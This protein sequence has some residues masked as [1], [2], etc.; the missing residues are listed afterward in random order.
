MLQ[1]SVTA[2]RCNIVL[3]MHCFWPWSMHV[4]IQKHMSKDEC[5]EDMVYV[6]LLF[7]Q[8]VHDYELI[9]FSEYI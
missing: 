5:K 2:W 3:Q 4:V 6:A 9:T 8:H 1:I 7:L